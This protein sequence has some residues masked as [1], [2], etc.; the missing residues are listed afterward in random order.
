MTETTTTTHVFDSAT[1][2]GPVVDNSATGRTHPAYANMVG[3]FGG[4]TAATLLRAV[5]QH[6][7]VLG[8]PVSLTVN[9]A[10]PI[11]DG[12][13][14]IS[15]RPTRT[16]RSTQHWS[17]ELTQN[18][19]VA[20]T[21]TAVTALRRPTWSA[22]EASIPTAPPAAELAITP[23]PDYV[24]WAKN[25][26]M[27][28]TEG[29]IPGPDATEHPD[30]RSTMWVRDAP[31]RPLDYASLT[32][33][34]DSFYPRSFLRLGRPMAAGTVSLTVYFHAD[35]D[36]VA[37]HGTEPVLGTAHTQQFSNGFFDQSAQLW[38]RDDTLLATSHQIVYFKP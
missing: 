9:Y 14:D 12:P 22:T 38:G 1:D 11:T 27:R 26:E 29:T 18:G 16:N 25:Y 35:A 6:P 4:I 10:G 2:P 34:A 19:E 36:T 30:S 21:A 24:A 15:V 13:F 7:D 5:R 31:A 3:P 28:F 20:T 8:S 33:M 17:L 23:L 32:A 37:A